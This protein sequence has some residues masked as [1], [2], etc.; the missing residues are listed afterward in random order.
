MPETKE[1]KVCPTYDQRPT[2]NAASGDEWDLPTPVKTKKKPRK[3]KKKGDGSSNSSGL[4]YCAT[5]R[6]TPA[7][8]N[9]ASEAAPCE[10]QRVT[11]II[12]GENGTQE[13]GGKTPTDPP[14]GLPVAPSMF[15]NPFSTSW[16]FSK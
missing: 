13:D 15:G 2:P 11:D 8:L 5:N 6:E 16:S 4:G 3:S 7:S 12:L 10:V 1:E 9:V 14:N